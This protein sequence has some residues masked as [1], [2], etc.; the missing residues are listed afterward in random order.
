MRRR[1]EEDGGQRAPARRR[2]SARSCLLSS[3]LCLLIG[4]CGVYSFTGASIPEHLRTVAVPLVED[5]SAGGVP[6]LD[7]RLTDALQERFAGRTRL[8]LEPDESAA[9]AVVQAAI[10]AYTLTP[11]AVTGEEVASLNRVTIEVAVRY[12]DRVED[13][14]RLART[15]RASSDYD[16]DAGPA[17]EADAAFAALAQLADDVFNAA[18]SD[19]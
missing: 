19:W 4:G 7:R 1:E 17:A 15:F 11:V 16:P 10:T 9:D 14:E 12:V 5:R 13:R 2:P 8:V 3:V 18:T 6:D